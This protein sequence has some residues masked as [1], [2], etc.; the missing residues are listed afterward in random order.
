[1]KWETSLDTQKMIMLGLGFSQSRLDLYTDP[2]VQKLWPYA[3]VMLTGF[4]HSFPKFK[5]IFYPQIQVVVQ[6]QMSAA[7][8]GQKTAEEAQK[9]IG[10]EVMKITG[11]GESPLVKK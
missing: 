5:T 4:Q 9:A 3:P 8:A 10:S 7:F 2:D 6:D 1:M 11:Q